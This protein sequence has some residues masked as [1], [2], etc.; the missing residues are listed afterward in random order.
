[1]QSQAYLG[2]GSNLDAP[3]AQLRAAVEAIAALDGVELLGCSSHYAS[4]PIGYDAQPDFVNAVARV[5][6]TLSPQQLLAAL[7]GIEVGHG[8]RRSFRNAPRTLDLDIVLFGEL[9]QE[10]PQLTL[11][12]PRCHQRAFVL[13]P[14]LELWPDCVIPGKGPA[15]DLL[16]GCADQRIERLPPE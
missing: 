3:R 7:Q 15:R 13:L 8:R 6:T 16:A 12:H 5:A 4:A 1:M 10:D 14:L 11:P 2:L 9:Q